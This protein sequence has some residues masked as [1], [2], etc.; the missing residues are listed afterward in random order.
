MAGIVTMFVQVSTLFVGT[1]TMYYI[2]FSAI[3]IA[4]T[5]TI[6]VIAWRCRA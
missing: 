3:E 2:Y 5:A 1:A 4:T 6:V